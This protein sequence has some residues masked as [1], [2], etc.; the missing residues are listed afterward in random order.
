[1]L[2]LFEKSALLFYETL[3]PQIYSGDFLEQHLYALYKTLEKSSL[4]A[5]VFIPIRTVKINLRRN[6]LDGKQGI[7]NGAF[8]ECVKCYL[9]AERKLISDSGIPIEWLTILKDVRQTMM[10]ILYSSAKD[11]NPTDA[12]QSFCQNFGSAFPQK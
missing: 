7:S 12:G 8:S 9:E 11:I 2:Q 4:P 5:G 1:M 6:L 3:C 10:R